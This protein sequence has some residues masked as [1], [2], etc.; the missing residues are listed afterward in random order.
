MI[1]ARCFRHAMHF[2][3]IIIYEFGEKSSF[4]NVEI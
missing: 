4:L 2:V 3:H 1:D